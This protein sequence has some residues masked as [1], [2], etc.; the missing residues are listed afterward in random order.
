[1]T[2]IVKALDHRANFFDTNRY[3]FLFRLL[4]FIHGLS[5]MDIQPRFLKSRKFLI[6]F[7]N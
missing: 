7:N 1:M 5:N 4:F 2:N 6:I 3:F